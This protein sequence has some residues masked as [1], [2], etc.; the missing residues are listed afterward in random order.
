MP[1][2][3]TGAEKRKARKKKAAAKAAKAAER[4]AKDMKDE[5]NL[6]RMFLVIKDHYEGVRDGED[7][8]EAKTLSDGYV[9]AVYETLSTHPTSRGETPAM[10]K[11]LLW[12][13]NHGYPPPG[14]TEPVP[15]TRVCE[16]WSEVFTG[17]GG[18]DDIWNIHVWFPEAK[19]AGKV[20]LGD[21]KTNAEYV[22]ERF[23]DALH[24]KILE[25]WWPKTKARTIGEVLNHP[26]ASGLD[27]EFLWAQM[28]KHCETHAGGSCVTRAV[29]LTQLFPSMYTDANVCFGALKKLSEDS[30]GGV[31]EGAA[32][33]KYHYLYGGK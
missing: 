12:M 19:G 33:Q 16:E 14:Y 24:A 21:S 26:D 29:A 8:K 28:L 11:I 20:P 22:R 4:K 31:G 9:H 10:K 23:S 27:P 32:S 3:K 15:A 5:M 17:E 30:K 13:L 7:V 1:K 2:K 6:E 18:K 25:E